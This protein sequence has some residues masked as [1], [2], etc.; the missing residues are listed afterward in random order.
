MNSRCYASFQ[1]QNPV[2]LSSFASPSP[3]IER[4]GR[5]PLPTVPLGDKGISSSTPTC[6]FLLVP[7]PIPGV[8]AACIFILAR[9]VGDDRKE[10]G[11]EGAA[12][13]QA[14][15]GRDGEGDCRSSIAGVYGRDRGGGCGSS[16]ARVWGTFITTDDI[17]RNDPCMLVLTVS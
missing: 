17:S 8:T 14:D 13:R 3:K 9:L 16:I 2:L 1:Q 4:T 12:D 11:A 5:L 7:L 10:D 6:W 15:C